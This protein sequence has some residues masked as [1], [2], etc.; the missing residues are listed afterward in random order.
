M[1]SDLAYKYNV[2]YTGMGCFCVI[3]NK[4]NTPVV[5]EKT[6]MEGIDKPAIPG[7]HCL[8]HLLSPHTGPPIDL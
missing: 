8:E 4:I 7:E 1:H 3:V 5:Y 2:Q 6:A